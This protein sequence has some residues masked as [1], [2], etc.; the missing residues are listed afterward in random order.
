VYPLADRVPFAAGE[1]KKKKKKP[2]GGIDSADRA[3]DPTAASDV[4]DGEIVG[5]PRLSLIGDQ[6]SGIFNLR[7][8]DAS[9]T[10]DGEYECQ[11]GRYL[12]IKPIRA[13]AHLIVTCK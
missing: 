11:V 5:H 10:D 4:A 7:I 13:S 6:G 12:R 8:T 2:I 9:L 3:S 1:E